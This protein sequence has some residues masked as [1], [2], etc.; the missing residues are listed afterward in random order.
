M[1]MFSLLYP[2]VGQHAVF[3][4]SE[5]I[6]KNGKCIIYLNLRDWHIVC[7]MSE[8]LV[9]FADELSAKEESKNS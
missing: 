1:Q 3:L 7:K 6:M 2:D 4:L 9:V 8:E 5:D